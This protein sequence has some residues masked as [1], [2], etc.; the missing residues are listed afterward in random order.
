MLLG[1]ATSK[2]LLIVTTEKQKK[3]KKKTKKKKKK[4][5]K[6]YQCL[7]WDILTSLCFT[8]MIRIAASIPREATGHCYPR[9]SIR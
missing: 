5:E 3:K 2:T 1:P 7:H 8:W 6:K 9:E 4:L